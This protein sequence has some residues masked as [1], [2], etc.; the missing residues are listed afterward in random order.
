MPWDGKGWQRYTRLFEMHDPILWDLQTAEHFIEFW[1]GEKFHRKSHRPANYYSECIVG[2][3]NSKEHKLY[4]QEGIL[5]KDVV[6]DVVELLSCI[7]TSPS[8][9]I[10]SVVLLF[11]KDSEFDICFSASSSL[12][13]SDD[14]EESIQITSGLFLVVL[15]EVSICSVP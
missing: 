7:T 14:E 11:S 3:A 9:S 13:L 1:D 6:D 2:A 12:S 5:E 8:L 15:G 4:V 10:V